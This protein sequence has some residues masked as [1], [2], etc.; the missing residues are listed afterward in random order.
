MPIK[1]ISAHL[2]Q[3]ITAVIQGRTRKP[4][5]TLDFLRPKWCGSCIP[6]SLTTACQISC[7]V[8]PAPRVPRAFLEVRPLLGS[9]QDLV[10]MPQPQSKHSVQFNKNNCFD[11]DMPG[12]T[13]KVG[14][15][16]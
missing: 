4:G 7:Q 6:A 11:I 2:I 9:G 12:G 15:G 8:R 1:E 16:G 3:Q 5:R 13:W 10:I 14:Q